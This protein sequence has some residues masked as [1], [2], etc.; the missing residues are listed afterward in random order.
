MMI[1][2]EVDGAKL[3]AV[4][5]CQ[6]MQI[7]VLKHLVARA[8]TAV[9]VSSMMAFITPATAYHDESLLV[10]PSAQSR[11]TLLKSHESK[12]SVV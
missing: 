9:P 3:G 2:Y 8:A 7:S 6:Q 10:T 12:W 4:Q 11:R 5:P 1:K